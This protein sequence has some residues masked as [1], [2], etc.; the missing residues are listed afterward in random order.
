MA[1]S[2][3]GWRTVALSMPSTAFP[4]VQRLLGHR[5]V[6]RII[7]GARA[8]PLERCPGKTPSCTAHHPRY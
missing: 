3:E 8:P 5:H 1:R 4:P 6:S 7:T 2:Q